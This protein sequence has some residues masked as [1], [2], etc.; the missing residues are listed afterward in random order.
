[1]IFVEK[2]LHNLLVV[3]QIEIFA[4]AYYTLKSIT[5]SHQICKQMNAQEH[6]YK[7]FNI[8]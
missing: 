6:F 7:K 5:F 4:K 3:G 1:M 8:I 2:I